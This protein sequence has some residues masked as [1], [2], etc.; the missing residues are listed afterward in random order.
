MSVQEQLWCLL[1]VPG[2]NIQRQ[3]DGRRCGC[4]GI[5]HELLLLEEI[6]SPKLFIPM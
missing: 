3:K 6:E 2:G 5:M 4:K 1:I